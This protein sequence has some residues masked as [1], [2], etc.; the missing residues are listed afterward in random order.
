MM[1][2]AIA[3]GGKLYKPQILKCR[4]TGQSVEFEEPFVRE[5]LFLPVCV[6]EMLLQGMCKVTSGNKGTARPEVI[7][8]PFHNPNAIASYKELHTEMAGKTGTAEILFKQTLDAHSRAVLEKHTW[9]GTI[10]FN[11]G[12]P[13]IVVVVYNRFGTAGKQG[14]PM[15]AKL[16]KKWREIQENHYSPEV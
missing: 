15:A 16:I 14:A 11:N 6:Q 1:L 4:A 2:A 7:R 10:G 13:D 12:Q 8:T 9:F 3:N 5:Q